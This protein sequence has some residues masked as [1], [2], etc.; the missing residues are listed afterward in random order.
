MLFMNF[1]LVCS[2]FFFF[3]IQSKII[4][5][6]ITIKGLYFEDLHLTEKMYHTALCVT[7]RDCREHLCQ[8]NWNTPWPE[9]KRPPGHYEA[10]IL[11]S[12]GWSSCLFSQ[13]KE[14]PTHIHTL[15]SFN[16]KFLLKKL[17][18]LFWIYK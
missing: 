7:H 2:F 16:Q 10:C 6:E 4:L 5:N 3:L 15:V 8:C 12:P 11:S 18:W 14:K 9:H 13:T 1:R 17:Y